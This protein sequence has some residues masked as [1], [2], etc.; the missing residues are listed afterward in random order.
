M[1][2]LPALV[3]LQAD[4]Y[5]CTQN[6]STVVFVLRR[7]KKDPG[8]TIQKFDLLFKNQTAEWI[9]N[10]LSLIQLYTVMFFGMWIIG[11]T[12]ILTTLEVNASSGYWG[13]EF[14]I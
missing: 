9:I 13:L 4:E 5:D 11:A 14:I 6:T 10:Q 7:K 12:W 3:F 1:C 8:N 2:L